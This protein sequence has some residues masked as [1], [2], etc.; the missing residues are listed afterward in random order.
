VSVVEVEKVKMCTVV[1]LPTYAAAFWLPIILFEFFLFV[2]AFRLAW[3]NHQDI[4]NWRGAKLLHVILRDNFYYFFLSVTSFYV[5]L[6]PSL[7][8]VM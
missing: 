1:D 3:A 2:L 5:C 6:K 4:G 8:F 7:I